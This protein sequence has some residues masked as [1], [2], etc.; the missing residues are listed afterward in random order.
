MP[1]ARRSTPAPETGTRRCCRRLDAS[2]WRPESLRT[3]SS[4]WRTRCPCD[5]PASSRFLLRLV[6]GTQQQFAV[7]HFGCI[8]VERP[9]RGA[10]NHSPIDA[11]D[12]RVTGAQ[13][14]VA[15]LVPMIGAAYARALRPVGTPR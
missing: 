1:A 7:L 12:G 2:R 6:E 10:R 15:V 9:G 11:E 3:E 13:K 14:V 8:A 4:G 5:D